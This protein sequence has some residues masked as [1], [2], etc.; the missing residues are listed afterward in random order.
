MN[1][2]NKIT[3]DMLIP[4]IPAWVKQAR[5]MARIQV[6]RQVIHPIEK[7][8]FYLA[9]DDFLYD[10]ALEEAFIENFSAIIMVNCGVYDKNDEGATWGREVIDPK[11]H[12]VINLD[13]QT[14]DAIDKAMKK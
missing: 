10:N 6:S 8:D 13:D 2:Q 4:S 11:S 14:L 3:T 7:E 9:S 1:Q 5:R 12:P